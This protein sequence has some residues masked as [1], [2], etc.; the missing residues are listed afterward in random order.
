M[1]WAAVWAAVAIAFGAWILWSERVNL[2]RVTAAFY[3]IAAL[4]WPA[5]LALALAVLAI[6]AWETRRERIEQQGEW[7]Q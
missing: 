4:L 5:S 1:I 3:V 6:A 7:G 2:D